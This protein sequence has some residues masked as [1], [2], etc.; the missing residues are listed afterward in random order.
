MDRARLLELKLQI[1]PASKEE[2]YGGIVGGR[3][4]GR[5]RKIFGVIEMWH[6]RGT[7][8]IY[9]SVLAVWSYLFTASFVNMIAYKDEV[10]NIVITIGVPVV[11][12]GLICWH[13]HKI[14]TPSVEVMRLK[15]EINYYEKESTIQPNT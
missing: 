4:K 11:V 9:A 10:A 8:I 12:A 14:D 6:D 7:T 3:P 2:L 5:T 1:P 13:L 15:Q